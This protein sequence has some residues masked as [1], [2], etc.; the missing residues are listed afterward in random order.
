VAQDQGRR[1]LGRQLPKRPNQVG[2]L[3]Q[4]R[5]VGRWGGPAEAADDLAG[6]PE[7]LVPAI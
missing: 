7:V 1:L 4:C 2:S 5:G 3:G 6:L